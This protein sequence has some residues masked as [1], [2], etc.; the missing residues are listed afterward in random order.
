MDAEV[1]AGVV[2]HH[3]WPFSMTP[4]SGALISAA[5]LVLVSFIG[6][7]SRRATRESRLLLK[8]EQQNEPN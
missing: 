1:G 2:T 7:F 6:W 5:T 4:I 8:V 3:R